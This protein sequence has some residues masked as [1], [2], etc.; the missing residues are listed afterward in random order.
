MVGA[1]EL[2]VDHAGD[3]VRSILRRGAVAQHLDAADRE[4]R[5]QVEVDRRAAAADRAVDV[6]QR[7]NV[8]ALAVDQ[9]QG[10]VR[11]EAAQRG[12]PQRVGAVGDR[13]LREVERG[14]E[15]VEDLVGLGLSRIGDRVGADHVDRDRAVGDGAVGAARAGDDDRLLASQ[16]AAAEQSAPAAVRR[17]CSAAQ[18]GEQ[19]GSHGVGHAEFPRLGRVDPRLGAEGTVKIAARQALAA[20][21]HEMQQA[22][23]CAATRAKSARRG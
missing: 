16:S 9:D 4:A 8:A 12:G 15:L 20:V 2:D 1:S 23:C 17:E 14:D 22:C 11:A 3:R 18:R 7:R 6:E 13:G 21:R 5:D 10:L 19:H